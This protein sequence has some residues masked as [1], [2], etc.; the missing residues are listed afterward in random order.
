M[1]RACKTCS[2]G[3]GGEPQ[4]GLPGPPHGLAERGRGRRAD[5]WTFA[6]TSFSNQ[7]FVLLRDEKWCAPAA[8]QGRRAAAF[9]AVGVGEQGLRVGPRPLSALR[10]CTAPD[11]LQG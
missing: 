11:K 6:P 8:A 4:R 2:S 1:L 5:P 3:V 9:C 7:Y 10:V